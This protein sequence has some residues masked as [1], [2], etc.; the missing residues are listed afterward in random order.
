MPDN[1]LGQLLEAAA[2]ERDRVQKGSNLITREECPVELNAMGEM[3]WYV[4]GSL[5]NASNRSLYCHEL[6]IPPGSRS[7][8]MLCQGGVV[9]FVLEGEGY[10]IL[11][12]QQHDWEANDVIGIPVKEQGVVYQHFNTGSGHLRLLVAWPNLDSM[13]GP[14]G[15]VA[16][17]VLEACPEYL[18]RHPA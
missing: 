5:S 16:M 6:L 17:D 9:S 7:G 18:E 11:D 13:I 1:L 3:R 14:S 8:K 2:H 12:G 15:G 10:T 4:H